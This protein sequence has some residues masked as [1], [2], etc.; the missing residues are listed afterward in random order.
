LAQSVDCSTGPGAL[1]TAIN[2]LTAGQTL[3]ITGTCTSA[4]STGFFIQVNQATLVAGVGG[5]T[6]NAQIDVGL[7]RVTLSGLTFDGTGLTPRC[8]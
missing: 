2:A 8:Q 6:I 5:A 7:A 1:Q 3:T 4:V